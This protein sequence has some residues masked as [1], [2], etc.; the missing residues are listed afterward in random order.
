M[1][2]KNDGFAMAGWLVT[3]VLGAALAAGGYWYWKGHEEKQPEYKTLPVTRG[4]LVQMVTATGQ[5]NPRT[6]V[7]VGCQ[8]SGII[9]K[10][11]VDF[12]SPVTNHEV[13]AELDPT[14]YKTQ[15]EA[16]RANLANAKAALELAKANADRSTALYT[17]KIVAQ[18][19]EDTAIA[20]YHQQEAQVELMQAALHQAE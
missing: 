16:A 4:D 1:M 13:I 2:A 3:I 9:K 12:N 14:T 15:V 11:Y 5:L 7:E 19:D 18:A 8:V 6:N 10:I 20:T 17:N